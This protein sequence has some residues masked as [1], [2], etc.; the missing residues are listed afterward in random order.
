MF[1]SAIFIITVSFRTFF[2]DIFS[3][4]NTLTPKIKSK[5]S[6]TSFPI[7]P[8]VMFSRVLTKKIPKI[9]LQ[10]YQVKFR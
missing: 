9:I 1:K 4:D 3:A 5:K 10:W 7:S 8:N 6:K 2:D